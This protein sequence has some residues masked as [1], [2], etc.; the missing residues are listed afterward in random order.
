[1]PGMRVILTIS[2]PVISLV[3]RVHSVLLSAMR[4]YGRRQRASP[5]AAVNSAAANSKKAKIVK[6]VNVDIV[7]GKNMTSVFFDPSSSADCSNKDYD[8]R[9]ENLYVPAC[10]VK[11]EGGVVTVRLPN[12]E[13]HRVTDPTR[14]TDNDDEGVD[15]ILQLRDFSEMS[16]VHTLR[17]RYY[18]DE[19]Y[20]FV[21]PI[22]ISLNPYKK[23]KDIYDNKAIE[24]YHG[25]RQVSCDSCREAVACREGRFP[26]S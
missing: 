13:I 25:S 4:D 2:S 19:I 24:T 15:D 12:D 17:V 18:R 20:T 26:C 10:V 22:L 8:W 7:T 9:G 3:E 23:M 1:M 21:G 14:V 11:E 16:L 6:K 5:Q